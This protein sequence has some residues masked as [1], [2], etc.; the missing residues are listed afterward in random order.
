MTQ[1]SRAGLIGL[2][3]FALQACA[4]P[5]TPTSVSGTVVRTGTVRAVEAVRSWRQLRDQNV[6]RQRFDYSCGAAALATLIQ[7]YF[8]DNVSEEALLVDIFRFMTAAEVKDREVNGL[9]LLDL[10]VQAERMGYQAVGVRI[11]LTALPKLT[12]PVIVHLEREDYRHFAVLRGVR[13]DR[14][15]L[16]DPSLGNVR[17]SVDRFASEWSGIALVLGKQGFGL[18]QQY[19]LAVEDQEPVPNEALAAR[20]SLFAR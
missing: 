16:A 14:V 18:P 10:R 9:S 2:L 8:G 20:R 4:M 3:A 6:V 15:Y 5:R 17:R 1:A 13:G 19:P 11:N 7:Y 12:G